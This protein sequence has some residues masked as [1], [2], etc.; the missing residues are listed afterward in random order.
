[1]QS[2]LLKSAVPVVLAIA[3]AVVAV[4]VDLHNDEPQAAALVLVVG[5]FLLGTISPDRAWRWAVILGLSI[6]IGDPIGVQ[7]GVNPPWPERG[8][9]PG[10]FI[11]LIPAFLG[12]YAGVAVRAA[13]RKAAG[14][15]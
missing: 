9:N 14:S 10:S 11:A 15:A 4:S 8:F 1:M 5:G 7:L 12:T 2:N 13:L 6:V 3:I